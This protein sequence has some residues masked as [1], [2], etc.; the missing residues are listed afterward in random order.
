[1]HERVHSISITRV[2]ILRNQP[3]PE[4]THLWK[5]EMAFI[6]IS[7]IDTCLAIWNLRER[8]NLIQIEFKINMVCELKLRLV[9][10]T[11]VRNMHCNS[12]VF[13][14]CLVL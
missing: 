7:K 12:I 9:I 1:M 10:E 4:T 6:G 5:D 3:L 11:A 14:D 2:T 8:E 13:T